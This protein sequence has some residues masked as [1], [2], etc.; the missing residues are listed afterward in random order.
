MKVSVFVSFLVVT[1]LPGYLLIVF[2]FIFSSC[3]SMLSFFLGTINSGL[4]AFR[5]CILYDSMG[6]GG[7]RMRNVFG[8]WGNSSSTADTHRAKMDFG[9]V[10]GI[11]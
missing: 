4:G 7:W 3:K 1:W 8:D 2:Y 9:K 5:F 6:R 11:T 10:L